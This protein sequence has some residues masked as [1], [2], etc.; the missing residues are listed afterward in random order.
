MILYTHGISREK[1]KNVWTDDTVCQ[2]SKRNTLIKQRGITLIALII[3]IIV[4]LI[5][6]GITISIAI[7]GGL[8][9]KAKNSAETH[10]MAQ[11][12][13]RATIKEQEIM[14]SNINY[15]WKTILEGVQ[16]E[17]ENSTRMGNII[18]IENEKYD[19]R[20]NED[21]SVEIAKHGEL[22]NTYIPQDVLEW[23]ITSGIGE[24]YNRVYVTLKL[25]SEKAFNYIAETYT[26][27]EKWNIMKKELEDEASL[28]NSIEEYTEKTL[29]D[30]TNTYYFSITRNNLT[31]RKRTETS[32]YTTVEE[33][34]KDEKNIELGIDTEQKLYYAWYT[35]Y[36]GERKNFSMNNF[37]STKDY[38]KMLQNNDFIEYS[39]KPYY[40]NVFLKVELPDGTIE[41]W[42]K[43]TNYQEYCF[44]GT[45]EDSNNVLKQSGEYK[46][47]AVIS[48]N[49]ENSEN[50]EKT[51]GKSS[52]TNKFVLSKSAKVGDY[53]GYDA[54]A[55]DSNTGKLYEIVDSNN[56]TW[57]ASSDIKWKILNISNDQ[58][59]LISEQPLGDTDGK[60]LYYKNN[61]KVWLNDI[62]EIY[63]NGYG[64]ERARSLK[65]EDITNNNSDL[66][67]NNSGEKFTYL[68][69][70]KID[71]ATNPL[72]VKNTKM[73]Y[74]YIS[75]GKCSSKV[76][77]EATRK[78]T[79]MDATGFVY[80]DWE[81][82]TNSAITGKIRPVVTLKKDIESTGKDESGV[83]KLK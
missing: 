75:D 27:E 7:S 73:E 55:I 14:V 4:L 79:G 67:Y 83:W 38:K 81:P 28:Y 68:L 61:Y 47:Y 18:T 80:S 41:K 59:T 15:N 24:G 71:T 76:Y 65:K 34:L 19:I 82:T 77:Y 52:F 8:I 1:I 46:F 70:D 26:K 9:S 51:I 62:C 72:A 66:I 69:N 49:D 63:G 40:T 36:D 48:K 32:T 78:V 25:S 37:D 5:L 35:Y 58:V 13:E 20:I 43:H 22:E 64:A 39:V 56:A 74:Y 31:R 29:I 30:D 60:E 6:S 10:E 33:C 12:K 2:Q 53:V 23:E 11:L 21:Y 44:F 42:E 50:T 16:T 45:S 17:F 3:T 57:R 54:G